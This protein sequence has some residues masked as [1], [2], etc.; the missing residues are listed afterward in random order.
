MKRG[1]SSSVSLCIEIAPPVIAVLSVNSVFS[2]STWMKFS[3]MTGLNPL[4]LV[5]TIEKAAPYLAKFPLNTLFFTIHD[6]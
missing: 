1:E 6:I 2:I 4:I 3:A 5:F